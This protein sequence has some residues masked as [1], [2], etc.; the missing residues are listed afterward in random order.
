MDET[1]NTSKWDREL[2][3]AVALVSAIPDEEERAAVAAVL[4][5]ELGFVSPGYLD[6]DS[7]LARLWNWAIDAEYVCVGPPPIAWLLVAASCAALAGMVF[8]AVT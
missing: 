5:K 7:Q 3:D 1:E 2:N 4:R 8:L 6:G